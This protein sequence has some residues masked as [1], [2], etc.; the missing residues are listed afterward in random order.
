M[1]RGVYEISRLI[2]AMGGDKM[3]PYGLSHL[4]DF[5][6]TLFSQHSHNRKYGEEYIRALEEG[7]PP[8]CIGLAEGI[9]T[10]KAMRVLSKKYDVETPICR[11]IY[12]IIYE[13]DSPQERLKKLFMR[14]YNEEFRY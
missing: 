3:T 9:S 1:A 7:R 8:N 14:P 10:S 12:K 5:E 4:G 13:N 2:S 11:T 6:A